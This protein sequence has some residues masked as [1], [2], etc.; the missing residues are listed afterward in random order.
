MMK[1]KAI[2]LHIDCQLWNDQYKIY[3]RMSYSVVITHECRMSCCYM[4][5][6]KAIQVH[7]DCQLWNDQYE[8]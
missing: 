6:G 4:V 5:Q 7:I 1:V 2:Q 8:L 3:E